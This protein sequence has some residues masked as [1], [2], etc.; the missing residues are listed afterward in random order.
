MLF[1]SFTLRSFA[2][3]CSS[4]LLSCFGL[5]HRCPHCPSCT[6]L[7]MP[8]WPVADT[9]SIV[10]A[11]CQN[12][13][14]HQ[15]LCL[16]TPPMPFRC[17]TARSGSHRC[18]SSAEYSDFRHTA[19]LAHSPSFLACG[20]GYSQPSALRLRSLLIEFKVASTLTHVIEMCF[21]S[22]IQSAPVYARVH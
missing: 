21:H 6:M 13:M 2:C 9:P 11:A 14:H 16:H 18:S 8:P 1:I 4:A 10:P 7:H 5:L 17:T 3:L 12:L 15:S 20:C 19:S 22:E